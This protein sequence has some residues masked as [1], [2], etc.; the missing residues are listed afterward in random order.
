[1]LELFDAVANERTW[2]GTEP[3][4]DR[5]NYRANWRKWIAS[6]DALLLNAY[7]EAKL[8]GHL[9]VRLRDPYGYEIGMLV[10]APY[11]GRGVGTA[12]LDRA[13]EWSRSRGIRT[14]SLF[15]FPHNVAACELYR[16]R[17]FVEVE[18]FT[19]DVVRADGNV[20]D[21]ILMQRTE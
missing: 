2:I 17:G 19:D 21:T 6:G 15:V 18:R 14:L 11:R 5:E 16:K 20:W 3:G 13:I 7:D 10:A 12:L 1:M 9:G 4:F 8:I